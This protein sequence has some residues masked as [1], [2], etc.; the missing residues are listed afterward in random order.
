MTQKYNHSIFQH[1]LSVKVLIIFNVI[2]TF[3]FTLEQTTSTLQ[4]LHHL[5]LEKHQMLEKY[6]FSD[7]KAENGL[8]F[9]DVSSCIRPTSWVNDKIISLPIYKS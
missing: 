2:P 1:C 4:Q 7:A 6:L 5:T 3:C 9:E 8:S